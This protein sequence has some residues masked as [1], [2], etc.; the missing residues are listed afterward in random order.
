LAACSNPSSTDTATTP[1]ELPQIE[2]GDWKYKDIAKQ[3]LQYLS[4]GAL[5]EWGA[6]YAENARY[7]WS[8]GD[9]LIGRDAIVAYWKD[10]R[11]NVINTLTYD[12]DI[13]LPVK[14]NRPQQNEAVGNWVFNWSQVTATYKGKEGQIQM[15]VHSDFHFDDAGKI[16]FV[17]QYFDRAP[18]NALLAGDKK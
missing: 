12:L 16:D 4:D 3:G 7:Y 11:L 9:C 1:A 5:D 2:F 8:G 6:L 15:W 18:I 13:W 17:V 10:R 14:I